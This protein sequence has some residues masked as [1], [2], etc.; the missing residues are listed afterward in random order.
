MSE[1]DEYLYYHFPVD[2]DNNLLLSELEVEFS[3]RPDATLLQNITILDTFDWRLY[4]K[5]F[6][7]YRVEDRLTLKWLDDQEPE[8]EQKIETLPRFAWDFPDSKLKDILSPI[9]E[10]RALL[11]FGVIQCQKTTYNILNPEQ[12]IVVKINL[13]EVSAINGKIKNSKLKFL[14]IDPVRGYPRYFRVVNEKIKGLGLTPGNSIDCFLRCLQLVGKS[15]G[16]YKT[17]LDFTLSPDIRSDEAAKVILLFLLEVM[18]ANEAGIKKDIDTEFLHDFRVSIRRTRSALGQIRGIFPIQKTEEFK[19]SF[20][21]LGDLTNQ[22]RDLDV[23]LLNE[24]SYKTML[25]GFIQEDITPLFDHLRR[26]RIESL[27]IVIAGL[28]SD[29]YSKIINDWESF[30][31]ELPA[32]P[33]SAPNAN[34]PIIDL[35][36]EMIYKRYRK[37]IKIG[38]NA[39]ESNKEDALHILRIECKKLRYLL[40]FFTSLF[41]EDNMRYLI[42]QLRELQENLGDFN[43][44][45]I[46]QEYLLALADELELD[47]KDS[48]NTLIAIGSLI[49]SLDMRKRETKGRFGKIFE[50]FISPKNKK[51]FKELFSQKAGI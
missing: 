50:E 46:Q 45:C 51:M 4:K 21:F 40:E 7:L 29:K 36:K 16:D 2:F 9:L 30:L 3:L 47:E 15:P 34:R 22:L 44:V 26:K 11:D 31:N 19:Q 1:N 17:K 12:K 43:D 39:R 32:E 48:R 25:P 6:T 35:A 18:K 42:Q 13:H 8:I 14:N 10:M 27:S 41:P 24:P 28:E 33:D 37:V 38:K 23:Y 5:S 49:G 20:A